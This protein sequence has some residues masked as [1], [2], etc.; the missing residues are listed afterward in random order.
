[1]SVSTFSVAVGPYV[2]TVPVQEVTFYDS[3]RLDRN[4]DDG[5]TFSFSLPGYV[6]EVAAIS[7]LDTDVWL[8]RD[9]LLDQRFRI[10]Q[11]DQQWGSSG[12][13][14]VS[15]QAVCYRRLLAS[16]YVN[17]N[18]Q[19]TQVSQGQIIWDLISHTQSLTNGGLG[20]TVGNLGPTVLR[21]RFYEVGQNILDV[22]VDMTNVIN[23]P[24]W[25]IDANLKLVVSQSDLYPLNPSPVM[26]G[27]T[28]SALSRPSG[29]SKFANVAIISGNQQ[30]TS[31]S[32][33][34]ASG[35]GSDPRGRWERRA[36]YPTVILQN[37]LLD[38]AQG[39]LT[40]FQAPTTIWDVEVVPQR[41]FTDSNYELGDFVRLVQPASTAAPIDVP[42]VEVR[43]QVVALS[44]EQ[45]NTG[46]VEVKMRVLEVPL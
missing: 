8:Y 6:P 21:D 19:F 18:L 5:C 15:V 11:I 23:G 12:Q 30:Q 25:E 35:L 24:T 27:S 33:V 9:G 44:V 10:V 39:L 1:M 42:A 26:L 2:G 13:D 20:V 37:T 32:I 36:S 45:D 43:G 17:T 28:A 46:L 38:H 14:V 41:F 16:R 40:E 22:I 4:F 29:A 34:Q 31:T 7:E 3:W